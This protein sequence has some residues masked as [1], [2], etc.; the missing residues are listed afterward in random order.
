MGSVGIRTFKSAPKKKRE[1]PIRYLFYMFILSSGM[2]YLA[3][4][5]VDKKKPK[6]SFNSDRELDEYE[7]IT[8]LK[9]RHKL[10]NHESNVQYK[11]YMIP[12]ANDNS[13]DK[14]TSEI[15]K[16]GQ[17]RQ[18]KVLDPKEL[19]EKEIQDDTRK[20]S[21]LLQDLERQGRPL[22]K[23]LI[24]ALVKQ[25]LHFFLNTRGGIFDTDII[26]KNY[27]QTTDEAIRFENDISDVANCYVTDIPSEIDDI[28]TRQIKNVY[29]YFETV[30]KTEQLK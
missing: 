14:V 12:F 21:Y 10:F 6:T 3:G 19:I 1:T 24:T 11:F 8:G 28:K 2:L 26:I 23:G 4:N 18:L 5:K 16:S 30:D 9:R 29:G 13:V 27:P 20:F 15:K 22:P 25:E 17:D 7:E